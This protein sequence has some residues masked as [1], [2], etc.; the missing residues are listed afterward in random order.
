VRAVKEI[1]GQGWKQAI[2][3]DSNGLQ[4]QDDTHDELEP[5]FNSEELE[6]V[7]VGSPA[8][9]QRIDFKKEEISHEVT[10]LPSLVE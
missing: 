7:D 8:V 2:A 10:S 4:F 1:A 6:E 9:I 3:G 5:P